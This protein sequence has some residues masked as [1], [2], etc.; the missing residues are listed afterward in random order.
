[1][2]AT[3]ITVLATLAISVGLSA[4]QK[5]TTID[6]PGADLSDAN[7]INPQGEIVGIY[8]DSSGNAHAFLLRKGKFTT[9][10][11]PGAIFTDPNEIN[12][13]GDIVGGY[14]DSSGNTHGFLLSK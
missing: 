13:R 6:V 5:F 2:L 14:T 10:D 4:Q 3:A 8:F 9:I 12:P 1:M 11:V 7:A